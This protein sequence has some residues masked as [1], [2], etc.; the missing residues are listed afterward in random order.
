M[1]N[2]FLTTPPPPKKK[3]PRGLKYRKKHE[4]S[5]GL[6]LTL[7]KLRAETYACYPSTLVH[8]PLEVPDTPESPNPTPTSVCAS[9][10]WTTAET[11]TCCRQSW[12]LLDDLGFCMAGRY[13]PKPRVRPRD[14]EPCCARE[15]RESRD[16]YLQASVWERSC[17]CCSRRRDPQRSRGWASTSRPRHTCSPAN[18]SPLVGTTIELK[19]TRQQSEILDCQAARVWAKPS[20]FV[21]WNLGVCLTSDDPIPPP[22]KKKPGGTGSGCSSYVEYNL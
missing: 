8:G 3:I 6:A 17:S 16:T 11:E 12:D 1:I 13:F 2:C 21:S 18:T 15:S 10:C 7:I 5:R 14:H 19:A 4:L 9:T 20:R 22:P